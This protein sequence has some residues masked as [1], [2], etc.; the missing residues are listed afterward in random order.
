MAIEDDM[1]CGRNRGKGIVGANEFG[2][3]GCIYKWDIVSQREGEE[4][5]TQ[6]SFLGGGRI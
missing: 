6:R 1:L 3:E 2:R 4:G 5:D